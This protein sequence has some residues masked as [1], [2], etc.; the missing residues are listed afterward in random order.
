VSHIIGYRCSDPTVSSHLL[1]ALDKEM[2][3]HPPGAS[4][5]VGL[6]WLQDE[7]SLL[8]NH[9]KPPAGLPSLLTMISDLPARTV[10]GNVRAPGLAPLAA[11]NLAPFRFKKWLWV[12]PTCDELPAD[13]TSEIPDHIGQNIRGNS[14]AEWAFHLVLAELSRLELLE[15]PERDVKAVVSAFSRSMAHV[16]ELEMGVGPVILATS[17][18]MLA[19]STD[20]T[21]KFRTVNAYEIQEEP[22]FAGHKPRTQNYPAFRAMMMTTA[23]VTGAQW[24][25]APANQIVWFGA[26]N[27]PNFHKP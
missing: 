2:S 10:I 22:L 18:W 7:R 20:E 11:A 19:M 1:R 23:P 26:Q 21:L 5:G 13:I 24:Q 9:P 12:S 3:L 15:N 17:K 16:H 14:Q 8:R 27:T 6:G 4:G 25:E